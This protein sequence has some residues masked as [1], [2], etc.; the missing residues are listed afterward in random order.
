LPEQSQKEFKFMLKNAEALL[1]A[2]ELPFRTIELCTGDMGFH[3]ANTF[4]L[5]AW[6]PF[7]EKYLE[8]S[9]VSTCTDFQARRLNTKF[10]SKEGNELVHTLNGSGL[11]T[12]RLLISLLEC[13]QQADG[14]IKIPKC[15]HK[16]TGFKEI[17]VE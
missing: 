2:L 7:L 17:A 5:E 16:Y 13:S 9:S 3:S 1:E 4:D 10:K 15:L 12:P 8:A 6:S 11:A 14:G